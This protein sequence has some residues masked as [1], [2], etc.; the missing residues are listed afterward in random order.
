MPPQN[1]GNYG[2]QIPPVQQPQPVQQ[3]KNGSSKLNTVLLLIIIILLGVGIFLFYQK[4]EV[5]DY[6]ITQNNDPLPTT[7]HYTQ[8]NQNPNGQ[9]YQPKQD[10]SGFDWK[11]LSKEEIFK[12]IDGKVA[13][14]PMPGIS[15]SQSV[16]L[17]GDNINEGIFVGNGGNNDT[18]TI[19]IRNNN[20]VI[21]VAQQKN[22][23]GKV[24]PVQLV[25][26]GRVMVNESF[27]ILPSDYGYYTLS[28]SFDD[29]V[30]NSESSHFKCTDDSLN[31]Y[32]WNSTTNLFEYNASLTIKYKAL[33]CK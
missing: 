23:D 26:V 17:T 8:T 5:N 12:I 6:G 7:N 32:K 1:Q 27:K 13:I 3:V 25:S 33:V 2:N 24:Y 20:G 22:K 21:S 15:L 16:D 28:L 18:S 14:E 31:A 10:V 19:L 4:K 30:D 11:S 29:T 9:D